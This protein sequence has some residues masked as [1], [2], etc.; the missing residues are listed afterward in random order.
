MEITYKCEI[1]NKD[2]VSKK[3]RKGRL[4]CGPCAGDLRKKRQGVIQLSH[5]GAPKVVVVAPEVE[6]VEVDSRA[7]ET[8]TVAAATVEVD[9]VKAE[10]PVTEGKSL[11]QLAQELRMKYEKK[12]KAEIGEPIVEK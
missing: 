3:V 1:C 7:L 12:K 6:V 4:V 11:A 9:V 2:F 8:G 5:T 10:A